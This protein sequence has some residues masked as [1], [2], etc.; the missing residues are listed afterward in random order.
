MEEIVK[1][2]IDSSFDTVMRAVKRSLLG[3]DKSEVIGMKKA[4]T[5]VSLRECDYLEKRKWSFALRSSVGCI[6][7][8]MLM[9]MYI[10]GIVS[11]CVAYILNIFFVE[12]K[13]TLEMYC[14]LVNSWMLCLNVIVHIM[15][16]VWLN[17]TFKDHL[18]GYDSI[19]KSDWS[20]CKCNIWAIIINGIFFII[21]IYFISTQNLQVSFVLYLCL[22]VAIILGLAYIYLR[23]KKD[24]IFSVNVREQGSKIIGGN[25][26][27]IDGEKDIK[28]ILKDGSI[29]TINIF[30]ENLYIVENN[31]LL[32]LM[33][34][35]NMLV[36]KDNVK[37]IEVSNRKGIHFNV[38]YDTAKEKWVKVEKEGTTDTEN[39]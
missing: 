5:R 10:P 17:K 34:D 24:V 3:Y 31:N 8:S 1:K 30:K 33:R 27:C 15:M 11:R 36:D 28:V 4:I 19:Q 16:F 35:N 12:S 22:V 6:L 25:S 39:K 18:Y 38:L 13:Q 21:D 26:D 23:K 29:N 7:L 9:R 14:T 2:L 32:I 37:K 20:S